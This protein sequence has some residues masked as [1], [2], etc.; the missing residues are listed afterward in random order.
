MHDQQHDAAGAKKLFTAARNRELA[1]LAR[2]LEEGKS[3]HSAVA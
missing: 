1:F 3:G 2:R